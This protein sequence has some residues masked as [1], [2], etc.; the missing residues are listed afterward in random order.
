MRLIDSML[1][2]RAKFKAKRVRSILT[3]LAAGFMLVVLITSSFFVN[4]ILNDVA[5]KAGSSD[6]KLAIATAWDPLS[7]PL[8][9][10]ESATNVYAY[11]SQNLYIMKLDGIETNNFNS[12]NTQYVSFSETAYLD[13][14]IFNDI[15]GESVTSNSNE[16]PLLVSTDFVI[17]KEKI[18]FPANSTVEERAKT[19]AEAQSNYLGKIVEAEVSFNGAYINSGPG[20]EGDEPANIVQK[21]QFKVVGFTGSTSSLFGTFAINYVPYSA[22]SSSL[23][24]GLVNEGNTPKP[25]EFFS[26][27]SAIYEFANDADREAYINACRNSSDYS[28]YCDYFRDPLAS[29]KQVTSDF[30]GFIRVVVIILGLIVAS[31]MFVT[32]SKI[33]SDSERETGVFRAIGA[34]RTDIASIYLNYALL[35]ATAAFILASM[36]ATLL[37]LY[38]TSKYGSSFGY[39]VAESTNNYSNAGPITLIGINP[40]EL[41]GIFMIGV[42]AAFAGT[43]LPIL[44]VLRKDPIK[45]MRSE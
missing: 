39:Q 43:A 37:S 5:S 25:D 41:L 15:A 8:E 44:N 42:G 10:P 34:K 3:A 38:L 40:R 32:V 19:I 22:K 14:A 35:L 11:E 28:K 31:S 7:S 16:L 2:A 26:G 45:A 4:A 33:I 17:S 30:K 23:I 21:L 18:V 13:D 12:D 20:T 1:L 9:K 24:K 27:Q 36:L 29:I 6:K